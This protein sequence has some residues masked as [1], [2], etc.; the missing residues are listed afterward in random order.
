[1]CVCVSLS[2]CVCLYVCVCVLGRWTRCQSSSSGSCVFAVEPVERVGSGSA[3]Y[4]EG[5]DPRTLSCSPGFRELLR[6]LKWSVDRSAEALR[7]D[8]V[9]EALRAL[10][11]LF[12]F[13]VRSRLLFSRATSGLEGEEFRSGVQDLFQSVRLVLSLDGHSSETLVFTQAALLSSFPAV[14]DEL[15]QVL[16]EPEVAELLRGAL[17]RGHALEATLHRGHALEAAL[18]GAVGRTVG[19][20]LFA[21]PGEAL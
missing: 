8:Q 7:Q 10:E 15:L 5:R 12:R 20:R 14:C 19:S 3:F 21:L 4:C 13:I 1:M 11:Y 16:P 18:L 2:V 17:H 6:C 9:Q